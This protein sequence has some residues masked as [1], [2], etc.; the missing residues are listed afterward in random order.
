VNSRDDVA[1]HRAKYVTKEG[2][3]WNVKLLSHR[4]SQFAEGFK[5]SEGQ[6]AVLDHRQRA[7]TQS[8]TAQA[9]L[10]IKDEM[11]HFE[12]TLEMVTTVSAH[13]RKKE[14]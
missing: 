3:W 13:T 7:D 10:K 8:L 2:A 11:N 14:P 1:D 6:S 9:G 5:L 12:Q 4:H